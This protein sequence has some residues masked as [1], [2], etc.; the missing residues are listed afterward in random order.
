MPY[1]PQYRRAELLS[2]TY[3]PT[4]PGDANFMITS[5]CNAMLSEWGISY[6]NINT[7]IGAL[8]CAKL[9]LY[10]RIAVPYEDEKIRANGDV[11][12]AKD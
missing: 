8:E 12:D 6:A 4:T 10:R 3:P 11:Y 7:L 2:R 9:E 1:I 5:F